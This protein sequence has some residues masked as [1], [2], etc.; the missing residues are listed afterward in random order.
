MY[1]TNFKVQKRK[2]SQIDSV[3]Y[4]GEYN[5]DT[6]KFEFDDEW[7]GLDKTLVF[8]SGDNRYNIALLNNEALMPFEMYQIKGNI[9]IG[10]FGTDN[11][12]R[13]L[14]TGWLPLYIEED[15]YEVNVEPE[16]LNTNAMG[17]IRYRNQ[18]IIGTLPSFTRAM[19]VDSSTN[20]RGLWGL[21]GR[22]KP[23]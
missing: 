3:P 19:R 18:S 7:E 20:W 2:I 11:G 10:L 23:N 6:F 1:T 17:C 12:L 14:A 8:I 4:T 16:N 15:S 21:F 9:Q 22:F 13:T 5:I